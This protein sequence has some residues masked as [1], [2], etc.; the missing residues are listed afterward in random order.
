M[1]GDVHVV[2]HVIPMTTDKVGTVSIPTLQ[3]GWAAT[4]WINM[5][6]GMQSVNGTFLA[7]ADSGVQHWRPSMID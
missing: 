7:Y 1:L 6:G 5:T 2:I 3:M 4:R